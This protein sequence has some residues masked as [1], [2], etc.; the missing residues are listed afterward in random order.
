[1][2]AEVNSP[3]VRL[4]PGET[5][6]LDTR[7]FPT[8]A[9]DDLVSVSDAGVGDRPLTAKV[10]ANGVTLSGSFGV[11][12]P[13]NLTAYVFDK[14]GSKIATVLL[15]CAT[16]LDPIDLNKEISV[17]PTGARVANHLIDE[18]AVD[19]GSIGEASINR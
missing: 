2:E 9:G 17:S 19:R 14:Q 11:F 3:M 12:F 8:R 13:G 18:E 4:A 10:S 1:M 7:W 16:P 15:Q 5:Y 6:A